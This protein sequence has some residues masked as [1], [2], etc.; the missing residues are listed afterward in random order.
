MFD[1]EREL[2]R[3]AFSVIVY[4]GANAQR[5]E[6]RL[7]PRRVC[8]AP[9]HDLLVKMRPCPGFHGWKSNLYEEF[10]SKELFRSRAFLRA[11][12]IRR[13]AH[14]ARRS[15]SDIETSIRKPQEC[16][17]SSNDRKCLVFPESKPR[18][19][20]NAESNN[21]PPGALVDERERIAR[22]IKRE[23]SFARSP[24]RLGESV[25]VLEKCG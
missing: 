17:L 12:H 4:L 11:T 22:F 13:Y 19:G 6:R 18:R 7:R 23:N 3:R 9:R 8:A 20:E 21:D 2:G 15:G 5:R 14:V 25:K 1:S 16:V 10:Q 24:V